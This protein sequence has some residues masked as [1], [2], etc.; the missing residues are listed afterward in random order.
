MASTRARHAAAGAL[1]AAAAW[2]AFYA[3]WIWRAPGSDRDL[4]IFSNTAYLV[5]LVGATLLSAWAAT[6]V[7][8]GLKGF[9]ILIG[10]GCASWTAG[11]VLWAVREL[12]TGSVP[13]PW[14][15]DAGYL[16]FYGFALAALLVFFR[17]SL[18]SVGSEAV[19]D[20][21]LAIASVA[22]LWWWL[23]LRDVD[24]SADLPSLVGLSYPLLD[25]VLLCVVALT[26]LVAARRGTVAGWLVASGIAAGGIS[27]G[28]YTRLVL[29]DDYVS[30]AWIDVGWQLQA[31]L[32]SLAAVTAALGV[33]RKHD[34]AQRRSPLRVRTGVSMTAA[35]TVV[36]AVLV[37]DGVSGALSRDSVVFVCSV[38]ALLTVRGW[39]LLLTAARESARRDPL[40]GVYDEPHLND[41]LRRLAAAARQYEEPFALVL[42]R[43][44]RRHA[45]E[46]IRKLVGTARELDLVAQLADGRL[47][48]VLPRTGEDGAAEAAERLRV[49]AGSSVAAGVAVW[50]PGDT[51]A[52]VVGAAERL[53]A[54]SVR[55][56]GKH[57]RGPEAD[58]LVEGDAR[59]SITAFLQLIRLAG[60]VDARYGIASAH[61]IKVASLSR[62][63]ALELQLEPEAVAASYLGGLLHAF[64]TLAIDDVQLHPHGVFATLDVKQELRHGTR[65]ADLVRRIPCA[66]HV[67]PLVAAYEE[68]WDGTGPRRLRGEAIPFEARVIAVANA[69]TT[70]TEPGGDALPLTSAL[71]EIWRLAGGRYDPEVVSALFRLVRDGRIADALEEARRGAEVVQA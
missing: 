13:F 17:P 63:L 64:G 2:L 35:L 21:A 67:A 14:W 41:Q 70:M 22:L 19:L 34:W 3:G 65:G 39:L 52:D 68:S 38:A 54:A 46:V 43:A 20:G 27:D 15:T 58:V 29:Q 71:S 18:R 5:P 28:L 56:G 1:I 49:A 53:L 60:A 44:P 32:I 36:L 25:L 7:P 4:L 51:A 33:G 45:T 50:R 48:V 59:L 8:R 10:L 57:T 23:V 31:C 55:L 40:R 6:Q 16:G 37:V 69:I 42:I 24:V 26:P 62:D 9:W 12:G 66:A 47:A 11:E 61:S 30:G